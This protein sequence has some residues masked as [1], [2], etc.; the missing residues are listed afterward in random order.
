[1]RRK[2]YPVGSDRVG[3]YEHYADVFNKTGRETAAHLALWY[4]LLY[5]ADNSNL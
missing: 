4:L 3:W 1:M 5:L 2:S